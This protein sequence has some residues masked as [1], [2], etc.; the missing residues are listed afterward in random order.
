[1][2]SDLAEYLQPNEWVNSDNPAIIACAQRLSQ[3]AEDAVAATRNLYH[4]VRDEIAHSWDVQRPEVNGTASQVLS[5]G[6]GICYGKSHL[7]AALLRAVK[8]PSGI[9]YQKLTLFDDPKDGYAIHALNT[10]YLTELDRWIR[11]DA[12]GNKLGVDAR[13][14]LEEERLAFPIRPSHGE[15]DY[16]INH[17]TPHPVVAETLR[18]NTNCL[19]MYRNGLPTDLEYPLK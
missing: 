1:M 13:F 2:N 10:V 5:D 15:R 4:F 11:L 18:A 16:C 3:N 19:E 9:S 17:A 7:L 8:I 12:R 14:S 6:H